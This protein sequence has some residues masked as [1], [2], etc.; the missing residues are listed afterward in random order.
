MLNW[1]VSDVKKKRVW[2][3]TGMVNGDILYITGEDVSL[4]TNGMF[5]LEPMATVAKMAYEPIYYLRECVAQEGL[6]AFKD[7]FLSNLACNTTDRELIKEWFFNLFLLNMVYP[8]RGLWITGS[9]GTGKTMATRMFRALAMGRDDGINDYTDS[10]LRQAVV[11]EPVVVMSRK[12]QPLRFVTR[13]CSISKVSKKNKDEVKTVTCNSLIVVES[14]EP[15]VKPE[16][17]ARF[18]VVEFSE[19]SFRKDFNMDAVIKKILSQ[20]DL[21]LST[22]IKLTAERLK[23]LGLMNA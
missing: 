13:G 9:A 8:K 1:I 10:A 6:Q 20:R 7:L 14:M 16:V 2:F 15:P 11:T 5:I 23:D 19:K 17:R 3:N 21:I 4:V 12:K 18:I 22:M